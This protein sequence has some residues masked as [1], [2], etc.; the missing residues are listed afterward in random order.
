MRALAW[1][2]SVPGLDAGTA[3]DEPS[4]RVFKD[5]QE[6]ACKVWGEVSGS[7]PAWMRTD[8][9]LVGERVLDNAL[10]PRSPT[11]I[12]S[13]ACL[14]SSLLLFSLSLFSS[15]LLGNGN[16]QQQQLHSSRI[17]AVHLPFVIFSSFGGSYI[18]QFA[19]SSWSPMVPGLVGVQVGH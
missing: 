5:R 15:P 7:K 10:C 19:L 12:L 17:I 18:S 1:A 13:L 16:S 2:Y 3:A 9:I 4:N 6:L 11:S 14:L 8:R